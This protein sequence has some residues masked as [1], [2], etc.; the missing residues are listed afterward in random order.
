[1]ENLASIALMPFL[2]PPK[3]RVGEA[4]GLGEWM[5]YYIKRELYVNLYATKN[6][7]NLEKR[8]RNY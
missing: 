6:C 3:S 1:M 4:L 2:E 8:K 5:E 7:I